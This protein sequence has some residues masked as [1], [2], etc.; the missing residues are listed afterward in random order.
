MSNQSWSV[1]WALLFVCSIVGCLWIGRVQAA[2]PK[3]PVWQPSELPGLTMWLDGSDGATVSRDASGRVSEW[4]DKS[5]AGNDAVQYDG[6]K[7]PTIVGQSVVFGQG[8]ALRSVPFRAGVYES[9][10]SKLGS[11]YER[12]KKGDRFGQSV[13]MSADGT[14]MA[15]G[16]SSD[17]GTG[18]G[19][20][21]G[22]VYIYVRT[23]DGWMLEAKIGKGTTQEMDKQYV[24]VPNLASGTLFGY[25]VAMNA[26]GSRIVVGAPLGGNDATGV[27]YVFDVSNPS[28]EGG[29]RTTVIGKESGVPLDPYDR[30]GISVALDASGQTLA[31]GADFDDGAGNATDSSGA[32]HVFQLAQ[33]SL[34]PKM[35]GTI[36]SS[37]PWVPV[38][39]DAYDNFGASV[40]LDARGQWLFVGAPDDDGI[41]NATK[42]AG[43]VYAFAVE[44]PTARLDHTI[45]VVGDGA[46]IAIALDAQDRFGA[47]VAIAPSSMQLAVGAPNDAGKSNRTPDHGAVYLFDRPDTTGAQRARWT[48]AAIV[49]KGYDAPQSYDV[50]TESRIGN[51]MA[52][53]DGTRT[54]AIGVP[55]HDGDAIDGGAVMMMRFLPAKLSIDTLR[56][57][58]MVQSVKNE[59]GS[60]VVQEVVH[61]SR[62]LALSDRQ[63]VEGY[64]AHKWGKPLSSGHPYR[65]APPLASG[66]TAVAA[67]TAL[68]ETY[69]Q[70]VVA[71]TESLAKP[72]ISEAQQRQA[73]DAAQAIIA[74]SLRIVPN[75]DQNT[76]QTLLMQS[77]RAARTLFEQAKLRVW[78]TQPLLDLI[79]ETAM[80]LV[81]R[82]NTVELLAN[83]LGKNAKVYVTDAQV[84]LM[85]ERSTQASKMAQL[86][87][88]RLAQAN[89][90]TVLPLRTIVRVLRPIEQVPQVDIVLE[91][92][93]F[94]ALVTLPVSEVEFR[95]DVGTLI[96][97]P[98]GLQTIFARS[99]QESI[100]LSMHVG[101]VSVNAAT[102][103]SEVQRRWIGRATSVFSVRAQRR[104]PLSP[105]TFPVRQETAPFT[106]LIPHALQDGERS[107]RLTV[108]RLDAEGTVTN[109]GGAYTSQLITVQMNRFERVFVAQLSP[110]YPDVKS[111]YWAYEYIT[112]LAAKGIVRATEAGT[113]GP[114][115]PVTR[116]ALAQMISLIA[117][118]PR[119]TQ[120]VVF[121]DV[122]KESEYA[123]HIASVVG[124]GYVQGYPDMTFRPEVYVSREEMIA[125]VTRMMGK[126]WTKGIDLSIDFVDSDRIAPYARE[127]IETALRAGMIQGNMSR[128]RP[129]ERITR[130]E[131]AKLLYVLFLT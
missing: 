82:V 77:I 87:R 108:M 4:R 59:D 127:S 78:T 21:Y 36:G 35:I 113:F 8:E 118:L 53:D 3:L 47:A 50:P 107:D 41:N 2:E 90:P 129:K 34:T 45:G 33:Q 7:R 39:L 124:A 64:F 56:T 117:Q 102:K 65:V 105:L 93:F 67:L 24:P 103:L 63:K 17:D 49:G 91:P 99:P 94:D 95:S 54:L 11:G 106:F 104:L 70:S 6:Q 57:F 52:F 110:M 16:V 55:E 122:P 58:A 66:K 20:D 97:T 22:A 14:K 43:I 15:I 96:F 130:A 76:G 114:T 111:N 101:R 84:A 126:Q 27:V 60:V 18:D 131:V 100:E 13:A 88:D 86:L 109:I 9:T 79:R 25:S 128:L 123:P 51:A 30:F 31:V 73:L 29:V 74:F 62:P 44:G 119:P 83:H 125:I 23:T 48:Q 80:Q 46:N 19:G 71:I 81:Q 28:L 40:A 92:A 38:P 42:S 112:A 32:V 12:A 121:S 89:I 98:K 85:N 10:I 37:A 75:V 116:A 120:E 1:R 26:T 68:H 69:M 72:V 115:A 61:T 5:G